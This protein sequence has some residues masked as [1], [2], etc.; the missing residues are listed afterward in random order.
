MADEKVTLNG[1]Q[2]DRRIAR[3]VIHEELI[4]RG[5][6][7]CGCPFCRARAERRGKPVVVDWTKQRGAGT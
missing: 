3:E 5:A 7:E 1:E 2:V 4:R 6:V